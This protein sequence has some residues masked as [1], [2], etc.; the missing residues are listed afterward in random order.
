LS[1]F[2][3]GSYHTKDHYATELW[4]L[5]DKRDIYVSNPE[6]FAGA[7]VSLMLVSRRFNDGLVMA[8]LR[9]IEDAIK[10]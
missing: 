1:D 8:A 10:S 4:A 6:I 9:I 2:V 3:T 7:P 5:H